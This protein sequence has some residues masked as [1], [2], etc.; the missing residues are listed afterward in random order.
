VS[1]ALVA[2]CE[3]GAHEPAA[4]AAR[5]VLRALAPWKRRQ[6]PLSWLAHRR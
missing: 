3:A 1:L 2:R 4:H 6:R 5:A